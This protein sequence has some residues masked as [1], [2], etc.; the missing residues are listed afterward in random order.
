[1]AAGDD[2]CEQGSRVQGPGF[3]GRGRV[4]EDSVDVAFE[5]VD[6]DEGFLCGEGQGFGEGDADEEC[7]GE[8]RTGGYGYGFEVGVLE[9]GAVHGFADDVGDGAEVLAAG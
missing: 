2:E 8:A 3:R 6:A 1:M 4:H 9:T 7:A 5:V